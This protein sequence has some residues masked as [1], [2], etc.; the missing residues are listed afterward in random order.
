MNWIVTPSSL[1][2]FV[3]WPW[4]QLMMKRIET[5]NPLRRK[6]VGA[7][8][9]GALAMSFTRLAKASAESERI[10]VWKVRRVSAAKTGLR[11]WRPT[12][13][14]CRDLTKATVKRENGLVCRFAS[15]LATPRKFKVTR[16]RAMYRRGI[17][18]VCWRKSRMRSVYRSLRCHAV[19]QVWTGRPMA[20]CKIRTTSYWSIRTVC[21]AS[22]NLIDDRLGLIGPLAAV[23]PVR[24]P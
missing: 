22:F 21:R 12:A 17:F 6:L 2:W 5:I 18:T 16:S 8:A 3:S 23:T 11:T 14:Q 1:S 19:R 20:E 15:D 24:I 9:C 7:L 10:D 4:M 13:F